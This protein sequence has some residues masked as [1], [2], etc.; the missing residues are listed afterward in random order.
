MKALQKLSLKDYLN[1]PTDIRLKIF[2]RS[3]N[4]DFV[5]SKASLNDIRLILEDYRKDNAPSRLK[6]VESYLSGPSK[7]AKTSKVVKSVSDSIKKHPKQEEF[8]ALCKEYNSLFRN[9]GLS[10]DRKARLRELEGLIAVM[11]PQVGNNQYAPELLA[12]MNPGGAEESEVS[13]IKSVLG[14]WENQGTFAWELIHGTRPSF[15]IKSQGRNRQIDGFN[16]KKIL[17]LLKKHSGEK[18][19]NFSA[20]FV[21]GAGNPPANGWLFKENWDGNTSF[22]DQALSVNGKTVSVNDIMEVPDLTG[23]RTADGKLALE[24]TYYNS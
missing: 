13:L 24:G 4:A 12:T 6:L 8:D 17:E 14:D 15:E 9:M 7:P 5:T 10:D 20:A 16:M 22:G 21:M 11:G 19:R 23:K 1:D 2:V 3:V 18:V